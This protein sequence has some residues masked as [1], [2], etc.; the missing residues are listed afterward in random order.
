MAAVFDRAWRADERV[1]DVQCAGDELFAAAAGDGARWDA[2]E[3]VCKTERENASAVGGDTCVRDVL[4][5]VPGAGVQAADNAGHYVVRRQLDAGVCD[6]GGA[7]DTRAGIEAG[8]SRAGG[9]GG[10]NHL[11]DLSAAV[12][13]PGDR[14]ARSGT[15][16]GDERTGVRSADCRGWSPGLLGHR[17][18]ED[19]KDEA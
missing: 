9:T 10:R 19:S 4:G 14:G 17:V 5:D 11:R 6:P 8:I 3:G 18:A 1:W 15:G 2:A 16:A 7:A 12:A 13:G